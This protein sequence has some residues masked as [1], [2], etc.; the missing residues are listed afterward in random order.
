[1]TAM[2]QFVKAVL[3]KF[4]ERRIEHILRGQSVLQ[5]GGHRFSRKSLIML[6]DGST[7]DDIVLGD[8][9]WMFGCLESQAGG[10]ITIE[11]VSSIGPRT[12]IGAVNAIT[13]GSHTAIGDDVTILDNNFHPVTPADRRWLREQPYESPYRLWRYAD[14]KPIVIGQNVWVG[15]NARINKGVTIGDNAVI[16]ACSVVTK[17][18]PANC[19]AAGNPAKI[20]RTDID[21]RPRRFSNI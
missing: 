9:V 10:K 5:G 6:V 4:L 17:D 14:S 12:Y 21:K 3:R 8:R 11:D 13:I 18:V 16:A 19:I 7:K 2:I 15:N 1:M 20:V